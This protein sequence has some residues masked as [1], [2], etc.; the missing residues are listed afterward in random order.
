MRVTV[1]T[2]RG[3]ACQHLVKLAPVGARHRHHVA[4]GQLSRHLVKLAPVGPRALYLLAVDVPAAA[5]GRARP[6]KLSVK[7]PP[8]RADAINGSIRIAD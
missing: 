2:S 6:L 4:G 5:S 1:T 3:P 7:R 8:V